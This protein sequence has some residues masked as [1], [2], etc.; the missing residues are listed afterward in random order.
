MSIASA[1]PYVCAEPNI[2]KN[3]TWG[4]GLDTYQPP[5]IA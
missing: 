5:G 2:V 3:F 1:R 4:V